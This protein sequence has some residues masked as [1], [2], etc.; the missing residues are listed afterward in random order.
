[1]QN[2]NQPEEEKFKSANL[3]TSGQ[4][5][6]DKDPE[7]DAAHGNTD[8]VAATQ[9]GKGKVD[10]DPSQPADQPASKD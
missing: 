10:G 3:D 1:M 4:Q 2:H 6:V 7:Q 9:K 8:N 5:G